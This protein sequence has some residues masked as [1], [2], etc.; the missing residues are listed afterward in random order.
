MSNTNNIQDY[1]E[2]IGLVLIEF[3][4]VMSTIRRA[5][6]IYTSGIGSSDM[7]QTL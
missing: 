6:I 4:H 1:Y 5:P 7:I 3:V 2:G